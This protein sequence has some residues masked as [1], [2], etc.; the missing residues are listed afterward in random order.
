MLVV[1]RKLFKWKNT[2]ELLSSI[3]FSKSSSLSVSIQLLCRSYVLASVN[4]RYFKIL[5]KLRFHRVTILVFHSNVCEKRIK[6]KEIL[7]MTHN[8]IMATID[9]NSIRLLFSFID[10]FTFRFTMTEFVLVVV[11]FQLRSFK[12]KKIHFFCHLF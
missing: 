9:F 4:C 3:G 11:S 2:E 7:T 1:T 10:L 8:M 12:L 6:N 5:L